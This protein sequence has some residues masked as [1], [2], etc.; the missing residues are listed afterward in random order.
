MAETIA[1]VVYGGRRDYRRAVLVHVL[2]ATLAASVVGALAG[3]LGA[4]AGAPWSGAG[5]VILACGALAYLG[6]ELWGLPV[7]IPARNA[8]VPEWWRTFF[9]ADV[10]AFLYG[11]GLGAGFF[12]LLASGT[13]VVV[14]AAACA[15]GRPLTGA[16]L[17]LPFGLGRG[18]AVLVARRAGTEEAAVAV[19]ERLG[20]LGGTAA[21][22]VVNGAA[23]AA[24]AGAAL[25]TLL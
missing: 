7:P 6:R 10:S 23:L 15:T 20:D 14:V 16:L 11:L 25:L 1:P 12:T 9:S 3:A 8:Q 13:F 24:L 18:L 2:G 22:R 19:V 21:L 5:A 17:C 4:L